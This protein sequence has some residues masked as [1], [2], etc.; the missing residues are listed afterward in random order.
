MSVH[1][2]SALFL[3]LVVC[4]SLV[5]PSVGS[6]QTVTPATM[7]RAKMWIKANPNG[8]LERENT[9]GRS[10]NDWEVAYPGYY[11]NR[12]EASGGWDNNAIYHG[13]QVAGED[14]AWMYRNNFNASNIYAVAQ[15]S[16]VKNYNLVNPNAPEEMVTG[17]IGSNTLDGNGKRHM[18]YKIEGRIMGWSQPAY[19]DFIIIKCKLTSTDTDTLKNFY[20]AR[21]VTP[22]GPVPPAHPFHREWDQEYLWDTGGQRHP[23]ASSS[24]TT[25]RSLP[26]SRPRSTRSLRGI[27]RAMPAIPAT[28]ERR[29][30]ATSAH[31]PSLYA[32]AF[33]PYTLTPNK[34]G[35][36]KVWLTIVSSSSSA[37]PEEP[38]R[39]GTPR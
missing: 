5:S 13:A 6:A 4:G 25:H 26:R 20:Y 15:T 17:T 1:P 29:G 28:S 7:T 3:A 37:P 16:L 22:N 9:L 30:P 33:L 14:V 10:S 11:D 34:S 31:S 27:P 35:E 39:R 36:R 12:N 38:C 24:T 32:Y 18:G 19:D 2:G 8:S 23:R 21:Y